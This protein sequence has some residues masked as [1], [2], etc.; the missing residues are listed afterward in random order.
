VHVPHVVKSLIVRESLAHRY[1]VIELRMNHPWASVCN[2]HCIYF[3]NTRILNSYQVN[4]QASY[5]LLFYPEQAGIEGRLHIGP[6][7]VTGKA[8]KNLSLGESVG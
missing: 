3:G 4:V 7:E 6:C 1:N 2:A 8:D 5:K